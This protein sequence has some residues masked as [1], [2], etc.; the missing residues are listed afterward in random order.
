MPVKAASKHAVYGTYRGLTVYRFW[1]LPP[2]LLT[3]RQLKREGLAVAPRQRPRA[4]AYWRYYGQT[5]YAPLYRKLGA[6]PKRVASAPS[7]QRSRGP[8][9]CCTH[10]G[11][12]TAASW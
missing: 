9:S 2:G 1:D 10:G 5:G 11:A 6:R 3:P 7:L 4:Y 8:G 12:S